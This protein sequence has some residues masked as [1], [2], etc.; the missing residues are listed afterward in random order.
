MLE[1][2]TNFVKTGLNKF[3]CNINDL[4]VKQK[5]CLDWCI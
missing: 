5:Y 4:N 1:S 3:N 2:L